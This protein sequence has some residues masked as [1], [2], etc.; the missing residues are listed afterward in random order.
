MG[1]AYPAS[2]PADLLKSSILL[3]QD[4]MLIAEDDIPLAQDGVLMA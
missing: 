2:A 4:G 3:P 1:T